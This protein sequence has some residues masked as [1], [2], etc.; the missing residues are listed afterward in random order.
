VIQVVTRILQGEKSALGSQ[1]STLRARPRA[2]SPR[3]GAGPKMER[4]GKGQTGEK[5][6]VPGRSTQYSVRGGGVEWLGG[7]ERP[8]IRSIDALQ[9]AYP[10]RCESAVEA[11]PSLFMPLFMPILGAYHSTS[12][13]SRRGIRAWRAVREFRRV[14]HSSRKYFSFWTY[15]LNSVYT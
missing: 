8:Q 1:G 2:K 6:I 11:S 7:L 15:T 9:I 13:G 3:Q 4:K 10:E 12:R 5:E 14:I